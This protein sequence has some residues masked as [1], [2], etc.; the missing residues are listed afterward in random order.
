M[1][2]EEANCVFTEKVEAGLFDKLPATISNEVH[3]ED[4]TAEAVALVWEQFSRKAVEEDVVLDDALLYHAARL[5]A[6]DY[7]R[8]FV[9]NGGRRFQEPLDPRSFHLGR[10]EIHR[11]DFQLEADLDCPSDHLDV[12]AQA[13]KVNR[14]TP[15]AEACFRLDGRSFL[16]ELPETDRELLARRAAGEKLAD[17]GKGLGWSTTKVC[18][19]LKALERDYRLHFDLAAD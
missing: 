3:R 12:L 15:E 5:R 11:I 14:I 16:A 18:R 2:P 13:G 7:S 8:R 1:S 10:V 4:R 6:V 19:R 9:R 17:I